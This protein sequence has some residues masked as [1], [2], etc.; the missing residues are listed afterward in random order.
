MSELPRDCPSARLPCQRGNGQVFQPGVLTS[1][2]FCFAFFGL[3]ERYRDVSTA[4]SL[5]E[6]EDVA[7]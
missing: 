7:L 4:T 3:G 5:S 2:R 6:N 1:L